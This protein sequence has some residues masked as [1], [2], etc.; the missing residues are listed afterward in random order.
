MKKICGFYASDVHFITMVMPFINKKIQENIEIK[1]FFEHNL[2]DNI[3][4]FLSNLGINEKT[5]E[6]ILKVNWEETR[7]KKYSKIEKDL[8]NYL[9]D[10]NELILLICGNK[11]YIKETN[12]LL[13]KL[14]KKNNNKIN[15]INCFHIEEF[16]DDIKEV[17]DNH[18]LILNTSGTHRI[19]EIF[20]D[21]K[22]E[23]VK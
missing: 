8:K 18:E 22:K 2:K 11:K 10:D 5:K 17:L 19:D 13:N 15:I 20:E 23:K 16:D 6:N 21:Y 1:T 12:I 7:I 14:F 3:N 9:N 4:N